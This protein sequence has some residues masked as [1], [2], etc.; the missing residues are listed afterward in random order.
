MVEKVINVE[1]KISLQLPP[2]ISKIDF[3]CPKWYRQVKKDNAN[4]NN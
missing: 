2:E 3:R 1:A 4:R